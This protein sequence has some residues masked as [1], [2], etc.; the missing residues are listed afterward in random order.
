M[1]PA[2]FAVNDLQAIGLLLE[3]EFT[4]QRNNTGA[5]LFDHF[6]QTES[7]DMGLADVKNF[8]RCI[9]L[10]EFLKYLATVVPRIT[11]LGP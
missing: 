4:T 8:G 3:T 5:H 2:H 10:D 9:G 7:T 6:D 11:D 1:Q